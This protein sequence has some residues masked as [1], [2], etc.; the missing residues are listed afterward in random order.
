MADL[1]AHQHV[2]I[3]GFLGHLLADWHMMSGVKTNTLASTSQRLV[4]KPKEG[5]VSTRVSMASISVH[6]VLCIAHA[7]NVYIKWTTA[8][9]LCTS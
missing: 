1:Y 5:H 2:A 9:P 4:C 3:F 7:H 6:T 8:Q